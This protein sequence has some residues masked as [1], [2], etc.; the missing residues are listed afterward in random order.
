[1][2]LWRGR[3]NER[4]KEEYKKKEA[5][6]RKREREKERQKGEEQEKKGKR[7]ER[8]PSYTHTHKDL[9]YIRTQLVPHIRKHARFPAS[10]RMVLLLL[11]LSA[12]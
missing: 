1:M 7:E 12:K 4:R 10:F 3:E 6:K 9:D 2:L 11:T 5:T 8:L